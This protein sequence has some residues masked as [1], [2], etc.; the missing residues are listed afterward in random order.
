MEFLATLAIFAWVPIVILLCEKLPAQR[1]VILS[2]TVA[3]LFLPQT[4]YQFPGIPDLNKTSAASYGVLIAVFL[5]YARRFRF[6][7]NLLSFQIGWLDLPMLIWCV[8][9]FVTSIVN[10]LGWYNGLSAVLTKTLTWGIPYFIGRIFLGNFTG[11]R[12][13]AMGIFVGG[14][15]YVPLCLFEVRMSPQLHRMVYG[16]H[17]GS[18]ATTIRYGGFRPNVFMQT[19]LEVGMWMMAATLIGFWLW[20]TGVIKRLWGIPV[21][22]LVAALLITFVLVKS[23]GAYIYLAT[24]IGIFF[25]VKFFRTAVPVFLLSGLICSYLFFSAYTGALSSNQVISPLANIFNE[26]RIES[27]EYRF[28]N[29]NL[30]L[31]KVHERI[32]FGW[33]GWGRSQFVINEGERQKVVRDSLWIVAFSTYGTVGL[34][35]VT[36][37]L[38]LPAVRFFGSRYRPASARSRRELAPATVLA[39]IL[40]LY[41]VDCLINA[42]INP[43]FILA[44]GG[45]SGLVL[46]RKKVAQLRGDRSSLTTLSPAGEGQYQNNN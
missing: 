19:G 14:L 40:V 16:F 32:I 46:N 44:S 15:I 2:F 7:E 33:G 38:L 13:L 25:A 4:G 9:P 10:G 8:S 42:M 28:K 12:Q 23:T 26:R 27:L 17:Q 18:F 21:S 34:V 20:R 1:A 3:W 37:S 6:R 41:M 5:Y 39:V 36:A 45:L 22:W 24:G 35:S 29:E 31:D 43:V 30:L 11:L